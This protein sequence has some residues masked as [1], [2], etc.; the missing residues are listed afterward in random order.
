M[1]IKPQRSSL[2]S[3]SKKEKPISNL[4]SSNVDED[5][6][7]SL[8]KEEITR[9]E[10]IYEIITTE[11][12]FVVDLENTI[13]FYLMP[14]RELGI[15]DLSYR[16]SFI[17]SIFANI[18]E[19]YSIS[20]RFLKKL[21]ARQKESI[22]VDKIGDVFLE[23][24]QDF[25][26]FVEYG[27]QQVYA[28]NILD[29]ERTNNP[30]LARFLRDTEK[31]PEFKKLQ[32]DSYLARPTT[33]MG[34][35]PLLLKSVLEKTP[36]NNEDLILIPQAMT[37][38]KNLL[39]KIN[40]EAGKASNFVR[41]SRLQKQIFGI[42]NDS[43]ILQLDHPSRV[44]VRDGKFIMRRNAADYE[45]HAFL[46]DHCFVITRKKETGFKVVKNPIPLELLT[47]IPDR[48]PSAL[49]LN[50]TMNQDPSKAMH[51]ISLDAPSVLGGA[52]QLYCRTVADRTSW[53]EALQQQRIDHQTKPKQYQMQ[54]LIQRLFPRTNPIH[55]CCM[56]QNH[57][58]VGTEN[59]LYLVDLSEEPRA[60]KI[61]DL[62]QRIQQVDVVPKIDTLLVLSEKVLLSYPL[63]ALLL[64]D[65]EKLKS[66][67]VATSITFFKQGICN[68]MTLICTVKSTTLKSTIKVLEP[69]DGG[70]SNILPGKI[71]KM[72]KSTNEVLRLKKEFYV[73]SESNSIHFLQNT[74]CIGCNKGFEVVD[75][76]TLRPQGSQSLTLALLDPDDST[77]DFI[78]KRESVRPIDIFRMRDGNFLLCYIGK[79]K[80]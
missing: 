61:T 65:Y 30:E 77:L 70:A 57:M 47:V 54:I 20:C 33:R 63:R 25:H 29:Q 24:V 75:L 9:Q 44:I 51:L 79:I 48:A 72:F 13:Q 26:P 19:I 16:E 35:Y 14:L 39:A 22:I 66:K 45:V 36:S 18:A 64:P 21:E 8:S 28:K 62:E 49:N 11:K 41:L 71:G 50:I 23:F 27:A 10:V 59:G 43:N 37:D 52:F 40:Y 12:E 73:P 58:F 53:I 31:R 78:S 17:K 3:L 5:L 38:V 55:T 15:I 42:E 46:F 69:N 68:N 4:W 7:R 80:N 67:K 76:E 34:R 1:L 60:R 32:I 56:Y 74:L 2:I 6:L